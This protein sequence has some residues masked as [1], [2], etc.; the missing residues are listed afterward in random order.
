MPQT[1]LCLSLY[2]ARYSISFALSHFDLQP[3]LLH[4]YFWCIPIYSWVTMDGKATSMFFGV[5]FSHMVFPIIAG[6][7]QSAV[8]AAIW[9][10][11]DFY[12]SMGCSCHWRVWHTAQ[13]V[14]ERFQ[15]HL[16]YG[17]ISLW[18]IYFISWNG[19]HFLVWGCVWR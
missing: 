9:H 16:H 1:C 3:I 15:I 10:Y 18:V 6:S 19:S 5:T 13:L 17:G 12:V 14:N 2:S 7:L 11:I 8:F 4:F